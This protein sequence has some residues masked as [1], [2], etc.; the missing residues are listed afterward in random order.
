MSTF[1]SGF[2]DSTVVP[3]K[4]MPEM[5]QIGEAARGLARRS[6]LTAAAVA[7]GGTGLGFVAVVKGMTALPE[8]LL[9]V[10]CALFTLAVLFL[11]LVP[12]NVPLQPIATVS[13]VYYAFYLCA[14][15]ILSLSGKTN[16]D[17]FVYI[18]WFF[19]LLVVNK[20]V[21]AARVQRFLGWMLRLAPVLLLFGLSHR[22]AEVFQPQWLFALGAYILSYSLFALAFGVTT[23]YREQFLV[24]RTQA[25]SLEELLKANASLLEAKNKA[26][27][28]SVAKTEFVANISHEI[29]TPMNGIIGMTDLLLDTPLS[30]EQRD[31]LL[32][33][34][35]SAES[36][37]NIINDI[38]DFSKIQAGKQVLDP[39]SF[40]LCE[41]LEETM[42]AMALRAHEK[43]LQLALD[44]GPAVPE[45]VVA[46]ATRIRQIIVN[47]TGNAIKFTTRGEVLVEVAL[48]ELSAGEARLHFAVRDTGIGIAADKQTVIFDPFSQADGSTTRLYGGTGLGLTISAQ[49]VGAMGGRIWVESELGEGSSFHFTLRVKT[50]A[51]PDSHAEAPR[52]QGMRILIADEHVASR[53][54]LAE[55]LRRWEAQPVTAASLEEAVSQAREAAEQGRPFRAALA[56]V[57]ILERNPAAGL[58]LAERVVPLLMCTPRYENAKF[59]ELGFFSGL[60]K[61][62]RRRE[63][64]ATLKLIL[65]G[66][67]AHSEREP[68]I[69]SGFNVASFPPA[70]GRRSLR[71]LLAED[72]AVNQRL[73]VRLLEKEGHQVAVAANGMEAVAE[74]QQ[75]AFD[76]IL[77]DVQMPVMDGLEATLSIRRA[78]SQSE[79]HIPIVALTA[80]V[81]LE[82][83]ER[84]LESGMDDYLSKPLRPAELVRLV[85]RYSAAMR[86]NG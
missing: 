54:I 39:V 74:W 45:F 43:D 78:E 15:S 81:R 47:L 6:L 58:A 68:D 79:G 57:S 73:A 72:N 22:L 80:H 38:L 83:R 48:E 85:E 65:E 55:L 28:A 66:L 53:R 82:D 61:P 30:V 86:M 24:E 20:L 49:L 56:A 76:L 23:R 35:N 44:I 77:M 51:T 18:A 33:V 7:L 29:R 25:Q 75:R 46:D 13:T 42:K 64:Y 84:C 34:K 37:L 63:L 32:T 3:T 8:T 16:A 10:S 9:I 2:R 62:V 41:C 5:N 26:E 14:G 70:R 50:A 36:L 31:Y 67:S 52:L 11:L 17:I 12:R 60:T 27:A 69:Q 4:A 71:I 1:G 19:P 21:N 40:N 59:R